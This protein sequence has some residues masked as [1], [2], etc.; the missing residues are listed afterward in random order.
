MI[1]L[2]ERPAMENYYLLKKLPEYTHIKETGKDILKDSKYYTNMQNE[3]QWN[4]KYRFS[5]KYLQ[6]FHDANE[7]LGLDKR[8]A[9]Q[10]QE[11]QKE[12]NLKQQHKTVI[13]F[14][15]KEA[16][17]RLHERKMERINVQLDSQQFI[18]NINEKNLNDL[19]MQEESIKVKRTLN[20][21]QQGTH[22]LTGFAP[23]L[24]NE[25]NQKSQKY[26]NQ[27]FNM[28]I[29]EKDSQ[30]VENINKRIEKEQQDEELKNSLVKVNMEKIRNNFKER[31][32]KNFQMQQK[33]LSKRTSPLPN[34]SRPV[35][36]I[37]K[38]RSKSQINPEVAEKQKQEALLKKQYEEFLEQERDYLRKIN[39]QYELDKN[40]YNQ[41][42]PYSN[43]NDQNTNL[44]GRQYTMASQS[45]QSTNQNIQQNNNKNVLLTFGA[46]VNGSQSSN[47]INSSMQSEAFKNKI[48]N[49]FNNQYQKDTNVPFDASASAILME[50]KISG[51]SPIANFQHQNYQNFN[52]S[53]SSLSNELD[54]QKKFQQNPPAFGNGSI[55][56]ILEKPMNPNE[57]KNTADLVQEVAEQKIYKK[58]SQ[59]KSSL[60][61]RSYSQNNTENQA[62]GN[63]SNSMIMENPYNPL[64]EM[65]VTEIS[66]SKELKNNTESE[67]QMYNES[68]LNQNIKKVNFT[69]EDSFLEYNTAP[70]HIIDDRSNLNRTQNQINESDLYAHQN[71]FSVNSKN[72]SIHSASLSATTTTSFPL[73]YLKSPIVHKQNPHIND[74]SQPKSEKWPEK[75]TDKAEFRGLL[76]GEIDK[77]ESKLNNSFVKTMTLQS[78]I[79]RDQTLNS[80]D[81]RT[82]SQTKK[83]FSST[84]KQPSTT[85]SDNEQFSNQKQITTYYSSI[86]DPEKQ[87][88][89]DDLEKFDDSFSINNVR[90]CFPG[91]TL[92]EYRQVVK[93]F[94]KIK[95]KDTKSDI[96]KITMPTIS[97]QKNLN[98]SRI[99]PSF[100]SQQKQNSRII[101]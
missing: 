21:S 17:D 1:N 11:V 80:V 25:L 66:R 83:R 101:Q 94:Q 45:S 51:Q 47:F 19:S 62:G 58:N 10:Q 68:Q 42:K 53:M 28:K 34:P 40:K 30:A 76:S 84:S 57:M 7:T 61:S 4:N 50:K 79:V 22:Y 71:S 15:R 9:L 26:L 93:E 31:S 65:S 73:K 74:L 98:E 91:K 82:T 39:A 64:N 48:N 16:L 96:K 14:M 86:N 90:R 41:Q 70:A 46:S 99:H 87:T 38:V 5:R 20:K 77:I 36:E 67:N 54:F 23:T 89:V 43:N 97:P 2:N 8:L 35:L 29:I 85:Y 52:Y 60:K 44:I 27:S 81:F 33:V 56:Q 3:N 24:W 63:F 6:F 12:E 37:I 18:Y 88:Y 95:E 75:I 32:I 72:R 59:L 55:S 78:K 100:L 49:I 92:N 13:N 69:K